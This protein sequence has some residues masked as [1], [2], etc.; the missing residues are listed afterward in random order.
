MRA[1]KV[2]NAMK[3]LPKTHLAYIQKQIQAINQFFKEENS[4][5]SINKQYLLI[6]KRVLYLSI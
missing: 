3:L 5:V 1:I 6:L 2:T 4:T